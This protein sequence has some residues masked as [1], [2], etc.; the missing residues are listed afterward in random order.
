[1]G[2]ELPASRQ[3]PCVFHGRRGAMEAPGRCAYGPVM[4]RLEHIEGANRS[5]ALSEAVG[6]F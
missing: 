3:P 4:G 6:K 2:P 5:T 1:M